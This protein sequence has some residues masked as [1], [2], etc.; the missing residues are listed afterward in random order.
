LWRGDRTQCASPERRVKVSDDVRLT[1]TAWFGDDG[2]RWCDAAPGVANRLAAQ[3][4]LRPGAILPG[5]T[6]ALVL[7][8]TRADGSPAV[9]KLPFVDEEN[10]AEADALRLY[11][12][13]G[14]VRLLDHD[15]E[16]GALLLERL[17]PGRPLVD[18]PDRARAFDIACGLLHRLRHA[19][20]KD[21][22]F[23][24]L[25][26]LAAAW[27]TNF[28]KIG[29]MPFTQ[30]AIRAREL[31]AWRGEEAV[32]NR[33]AHLGNVLSASREPWLLIDPKPVVGDP[34]F[35]GAFLLL[36]N[37]NAQTPGLVQRIAQ[38]LAVDADRLRGWAYLR[39]VDN[40]LWATDLGDAT[41]T[42]E[43]AALAR[44]LDDPD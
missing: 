22:R 34:A 33:D 2:R 12:G 40:I 21:H 5:A 35:D 30:A 44:L 25:R 16:S 24:L 43:Y 6:H 42:A 9:L 10:R 26:D 15:P 14:A 13:D 18:L 37:L 19:P 20:P 3:W 41:R 17:V 32:V 27:A 38:G 36:R 1:I 31:G 29:R 39:A 8:C 4:K 11:D 7:A 28:S 23:P